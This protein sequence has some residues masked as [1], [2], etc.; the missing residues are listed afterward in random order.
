MIEDA[1]T[2]TATLMWPLDARR[3]RFRLG[4]LLI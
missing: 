1:L 3:V 2:W 4:L